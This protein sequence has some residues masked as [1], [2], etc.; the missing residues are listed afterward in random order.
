MAK[1]RKRIHYSWVRR[2]RPLINSHFKWQW[3][4]DPGL[5]FAP[6]FFLRPPLP[7]ASGALA[8][9]LAWSSANDQHDVCAM[10]RR[11]TL[12]LEAVVP[13]LRPPSWGGNRAQAGCPERYG[14]SS[15]ARTHR[16]NLEGRWKGRG[17]GGTLIGERTGWRERDLLRNVRNTRAWIHPPEI[18]GHKDT[19]ASRDPFF[20]SQRLSIDAL[21][22]VLT[23]TLRDC[24][25]ELHFGS[26]L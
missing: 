20:F 26:L 3:V 4:T 11:L 13:L 23:Q 18:A 22:S 6:S 10:E 2:Q 16:V 17:W 24:V 8:K 15:L 21:H 14:N 25:L 5:F 19:D 7:A 1:L 12:E 9:G